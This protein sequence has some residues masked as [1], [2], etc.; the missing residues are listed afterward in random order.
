MT[1][2]NQNQ[3][4][5]ISLVELIV[6][7]LKNWKPAVCT[8]LVT[9]LLAVSLVALLTP[10]YD[11]K[12]SLQVS[13]L[14]KELLVEPAVLVAQLKAAHR[15]G[16]DTQ[17]LRPLPR[18]ESVSSNKR[19][20]S[21]VIEFLA[22]A[23]SAE[24]AAEFL[25][26]LTQKIIESHSVIYQKSRAEKQALY[27][28]LTAQKGGNGEVLAQI[29]NDLAVMTP[30]SL[31]SPPSIPVKPTA[32]KKTLLYAVSLAL[33]FIVM[34]VLPFLLVFVNGVKEELQRQAEK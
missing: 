17:G 20:D 27:D 21:P 3:Y 18:L 1:L 19:D 8:G 6:M 29:Q 25:Q 22:R 11:S 15:V 31:L 14:G 10:K 30:S 32:P 5:E 13:R 16:D 4:E 24:S 26:A 7:W 12:V 9:I 28:Q 23:K 34:L 2:E 33:G